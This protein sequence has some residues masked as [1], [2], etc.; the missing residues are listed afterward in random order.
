MNTSSRLTQAD[1]QLHTLK[2]REGCAFAATVPALA[3]L[4]QL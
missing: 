1:K 4:V 2:F 3:L